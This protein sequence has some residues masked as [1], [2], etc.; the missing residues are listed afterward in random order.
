MDGQH[1]LIMNI[2]ATTIPDEQ[3]A[4]L[5]QQFRITT[6]ADGGDFITQ[7]AAA[8]YLQSNKRAAIAAIA[9]DQDGTKTAAASTALA[10]AGASMKMPSLPAATVVATSPIKTTGSASVAPKK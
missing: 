1:E 6:Y 2:P 3:A 5:A 10:G 8:A 7:V 9:S 4:A